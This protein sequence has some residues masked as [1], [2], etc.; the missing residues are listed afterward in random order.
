MMTLNDSDFFT[1]YASRYAL[2][3]ECF[4]PEMRCTLRKKVLYETNESFQLATK[5]KN[6]FIHGTKPLKKFP[7]QLAIV[8]K[9]S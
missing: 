6:S 5:L 1:E 9:V 2:F 7:R 4:A 8:L 3:R